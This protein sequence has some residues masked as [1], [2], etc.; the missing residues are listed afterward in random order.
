M[1][2]LHK[3]KKKKTVYIL[4]FDYCY[5]TCMLMLLH[6]YQCA[7]VVTSKN[8]FMYCKEHVYTRRLLVGAFNP[9][10]PEADLSS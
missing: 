9:F 4:Y 3:K 1:R 2:E 6:C 7:R 8:M 10:H 5:S